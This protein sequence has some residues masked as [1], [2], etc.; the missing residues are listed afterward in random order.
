MGAAGVISLQSMIGNIF[1][2]ALGGKDSC[3]G[4]SGG[5]LVVRD[6][7]NG[8]AATLLG[9]VNRGLDGSACGRPGMPG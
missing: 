5:P 8:G 7:K 9:V 3:H 6:P 1:F 4:D 2:D